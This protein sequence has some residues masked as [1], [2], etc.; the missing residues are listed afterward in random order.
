MPEVDQPKE[1]SNAADIAM[2]LSLATDFL[3]GLIAAAAAILLAAGIASSAWPRTAATVASHRIESVVLKSYGTPR[4]GRSTPLKIET[5]EYQYIVDGSTFSGTQVCFC[6]PLG[7]PSP[8]FEPRSPTVAY[9]PF[10]PSIA[11]LFPGAD[12]LSV[13]ALLSL[14]AAVFATGRFLPSYFRQQSNE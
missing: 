1:G 2:R 5:A 7:A 8:N 6:L 11:V 12:M 9:Y 13:L 3:S 10:D 4:S 14:A